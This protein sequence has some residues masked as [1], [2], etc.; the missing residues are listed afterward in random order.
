MRDI[1]K[2]R[3]RHRQRE[4]KQAPY[5]EPDAGLHP[6][7]QGSHLELKSDTQ[8]LSHPSAPINFILLHVEIIMFYMYWA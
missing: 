7:T 3:Q 6:E 2:E 5:K 8:P 4:E 1:E